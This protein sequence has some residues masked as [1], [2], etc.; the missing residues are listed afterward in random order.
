[1]AVVAL[2]AVLIEEEEEQDDPPCPVYLTSTI[3]V[4]FRLISFSNLHLIAS[5]SRL[6]VDLAGPGHNHNRS[7]LHQEAGNNSHLG[8]SSNK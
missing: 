7:F 4:H 5:L 6:A 8:S 1:L 2:V 3:S